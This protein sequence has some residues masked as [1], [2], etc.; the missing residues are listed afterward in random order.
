MDERNENRPESGSKEFPFYGIHNEKD[1]RRSGQSARRYILVHDVERCSCDGNGE[2]RPD[3]SDRAPARPLARETHAR[4]APATQRQKKNR[5][6]LPT[7]ERPAERKMSEPHGISD[8][9]GKQRHVGVRGKEL[10][11]VRIERWMKKPLDSG[12]VN[13]RAAG[14]FAGEE[15]DS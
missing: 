9:A 1:N 8:Q 7:E 11:V 4:Q 12:N 3:Q 14:F 6:K 5:K 2:Q 15:S 10:R 13:F